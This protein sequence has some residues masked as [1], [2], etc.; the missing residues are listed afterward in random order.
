MDSVVFVDDRLG[1]ERLAHHAAP[2]PGRRSA[3][4]R[5]EKA[6]GSDASYV[7]F[8]RQLRP[9]W[10]RSGVASAAAGMSGAAS[11]DPAPYWNQ[12]GIL[13]SMYGAFIRSVR[14]SRGLSQM[15]LAR[16]VGIDQPNLS[17]Y[18][19]DRQLPS[20]DMLNKIAVACGYL[21][22]AVAGGRR[23]TCPLPRAGW[24]PDDDYRDDVT[25]P[26][27]ATASSATPRTTSADIEERA[28]HL[29]QVLAMSDAM[30]EAK[31]LR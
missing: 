22:E 5:A 14:Q 7:R 31:I 10:P 27:L 8:A 23:I 1:D 20:A 26:T 19:N 11:S 24:F 29:E 21:L 17:A 16:V 28:V 30:R 18:E 15:E 4:N 13:M 2:A 9:T 6:L 25:E 12:Y 3:K